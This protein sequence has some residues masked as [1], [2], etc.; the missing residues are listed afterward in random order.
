MHLLRVCRVFWLEV[1]SDTRL[2]FCA[3][4]RGTYLV[5]VIY[6]Y[7]YIYIARDL[8]GTAC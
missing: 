3:T 4:T 5:Y 6:V 8:H 1:Y 2:H 7:V